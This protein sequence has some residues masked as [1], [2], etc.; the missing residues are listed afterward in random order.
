MRGAYGLVIRI[1]CR[2][3]EDFVE[4]SVGQ[5][6]GEV[7]HSGG[8]SEAGEPQALGKRKALPYRG[9]R[10]I[11]FGVSEFSTMYEVQHTSYTTGVVM[12]RPDKG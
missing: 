7:R 1:K 6:C 2:A 9:T 3:D 10:L 4:W 5:V 8:V 12:G 11:S